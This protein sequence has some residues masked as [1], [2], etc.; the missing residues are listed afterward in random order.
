MQHTDTATYFVNTEDY[1]RKTKTKNEYTN[2]KMYLSKICT[3]DDT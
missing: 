3:E 1:S 2:S